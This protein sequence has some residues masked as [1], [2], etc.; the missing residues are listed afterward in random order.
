MVGTV[1]L[2]VGTT[3]ASLPPAVLW[4]QMTGMLLGRLEFFVVFAA[5]AGLLRGLRRLVAPALSRRAGK[6]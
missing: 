2:S 6:R 5:L 3:S 1:G 4:V